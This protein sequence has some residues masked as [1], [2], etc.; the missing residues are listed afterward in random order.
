[1]VNSNEPLK[2]RMAREE[3]VAKPS[4]LAG[5]ARARD[6]ALFRR[7]FV[8]TAIAGL[9]LSYWHSPWWLLLFV[10][11]GAGLLHDILRLRKER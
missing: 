2:E 7:Y 8:A 10:P 6:R 1:M 4:S 3:M 5:A 11:L 9:Q